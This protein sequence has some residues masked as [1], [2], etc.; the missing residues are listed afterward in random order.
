LALKGAKL[1]LN[2]SWSGKISFI[3][4]K[5]RESDKRFSFF[6]GSTQWDESKRVTKLS[7]LKRLL[8]STKKN[9]C[10]TSRRTKAKILNHIVKIFQS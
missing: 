7:H 5:K 2:A 9:F 6:V 3:K 4:P 1:H 8:W 10:K